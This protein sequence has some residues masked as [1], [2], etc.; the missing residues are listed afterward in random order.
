MEILGDW[1]APVRSLSMKS[2]SSVA[3]SLCPE[4]RKVIAIQ[5]PS[6]S[7]PTGHIAAELQVSRKF[8]YQQAHKA[9]EVLEKQQVTRSMRSR[10][11]HAKRRKR[12]LVSLAKDL[13]PL[14]KWMSHD[15]LELAGP[16]LEVRQELFDFIV[17]ELQQLECKQNPNIRKF[18]RR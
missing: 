4:V 3:S 15:V 14:S 13:N 16:P 9:Q 7:E 10:L 6:K 1:C 18:A 8:V 17:S 11:P 2:A 12:E 5:A